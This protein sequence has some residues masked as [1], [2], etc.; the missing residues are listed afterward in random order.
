MALF[1]FDVYII[2]GQAMVTGGLRS[3]S[4]GFYTAAS[5][6]MGLGV[7]QLEQLKRGGRLLAR[8]D[9]VPLARR[10]GDVSILDFFPCLTC[11]YLFYDS[12]GAADGDGDV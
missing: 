1:S 8:G 6:A 7:E 5:M 12:R 2:R 3:R 11:F 4:V 10:R 9:V